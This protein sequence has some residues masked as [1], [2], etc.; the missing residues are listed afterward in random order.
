MQREELHAAPPCKGKNSVA[1]TWSSALYMH[2]AGRGAQS[3]RPPAQ[4]QAGAKILC[5]LQFV[6]K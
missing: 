1:S 5:T 2:P 6:V 3:K 4:W